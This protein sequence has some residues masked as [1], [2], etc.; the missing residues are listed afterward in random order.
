MSSLFGFGLFNFG[1]LFGK[2]KTKK[3][4]S[5]KPKESAKNLKLNTRRKGTNGRMYVVK[6]VQRN[7]R[8]VKTWVSAAKAKSDRFHKYN[9]YVRS[10]NRKGP[11][12]SAT[13]YK[14][15]TRKRG[16]DKDRNMY[17]VIKSGKS[18]RWVKVA[19]K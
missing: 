7:G 17:R 11:I 4:S 12:Q 9:R 6:S 18:K 14:I 8:K 16:R 13:L 2:K 15:G 3:K 19:K 5:G 10:P 1:S